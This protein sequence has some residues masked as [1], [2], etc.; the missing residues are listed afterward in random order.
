V[1]GFAGYVVEKIETIASV[2]DKAISLC[3][4]SSNGLS[5]ERIMDAAIEVLSATAAVIERFSPVGGPA[6]GADLL[7]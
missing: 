4:S 3:N 2:G 1:G 7:R 6:A 5:I